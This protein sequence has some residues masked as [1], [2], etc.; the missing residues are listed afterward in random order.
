MALKLLEEWHD[1]G[2]TMD[3]VM[4]RK[5][6]GSTYVDPHEDEKV[7]FKDLPDRFPSLLS[8]DFRNEVGQ[9]EDFDNLYAMYLLYNLGKYRVLVNEQDAAARNRAGQGSDRLSPGGKARRRGREGGQQQLSSTAGV[10]PQ[11]YANRAIRHRPRRT[12]ARRSGHR[13]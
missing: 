2:Y 3:V 6:G 10:P 12:V 9:Y 13:R 8:R 5:Y 1:R 11:G 4:Y 7:A